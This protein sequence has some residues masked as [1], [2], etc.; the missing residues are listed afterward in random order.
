MSSPFTNWVKK[1]R[2]TYDSTDSGGVFKVFTAEGV[3][4]STFTS[5]G[6]HAI[7]L[8]DHPE[9]AFLLVNDAAFTF[10]DSPVKTVHNNN[11]GFTK[12][13]VHQATLAHCIM[14]MIGAPTKREYQALAHLNLLQDCP[15]TN[16]NIVNAHKIFGP[17]LANIR[18]KKVCRQP[19]HVS[20]EIVNIPQQILENQ[21]NVT[22]SADIMFVNG[23]LFLV[24]LSRNINLTTIEYVPHCTASKL[25]LLLHR[26]ITIYARAGFTIQTILL[27]NKFDKVKD[28][29]RTP[30][31]T[32]LL[33]L[34]TLVTSNTEFVS[35]KSV[36][37]DL[38]VPSPIPASHKSCSFIFSTML[39]CGFII[40]RWAMVSLID[41][42]LAKNESSVT[43]YTD[44]V[45][46]SMTRV[47][48]KS[49]S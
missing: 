22:L 21:S 30:S 25:G 34:N 28:M 35:S 48:H 1:F 33:L 6:L 37:E 45:Y 31:S 15:F 41:S 36:V 4:E 13:Q 2:V 44:W 20:M 19:E 47:L 38:C 3:V 16:S 49:S 14:G 5:K 18:G 24:L 39:S 29:S 8:W 26:I 42:A 17:D 32:R 7:N 12:K 23:V 27:D 43:N 10:G 9:A 46:P 11:E 40:C